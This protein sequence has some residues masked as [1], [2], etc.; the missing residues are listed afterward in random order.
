MEKE[1][2]GEGQ[3]KSQ[4]KVVIDVTEEGGVCGRRGDWK[5]RV[6]YTLKGFVVK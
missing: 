6:L 2:Q 5:R 1:G 3:R 4:S